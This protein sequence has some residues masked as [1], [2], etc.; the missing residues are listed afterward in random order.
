VSTI[1]PESNEIRGTTRW[2]EVP[3]QAGALAGSAAG[4]EACREAGRA[5]SGEHPREGG[6]RAGDGGETHHAG[7]RR[8]VVVDEAA[9]LARGLEPHG[10]DD[11]LREQAR[12]EGDGERR[13]LDL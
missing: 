6:G 8:V 1:F 5:A 3:R 11:L 9:G 12:P 4:G 2:G 7:D 10:L 13:E